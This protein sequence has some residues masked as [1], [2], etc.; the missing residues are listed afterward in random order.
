[1]KDPISHALEQRDIAMMKRYEEARQIVKD[2]AEVISM[3]SLEDIVKKY[4]HTNPGEV[5]NS[6]DVFRMFKDYPVDTWT[7]NN[8][9]RI[10]LAM[11]YMFTQE[12]FKVEEQ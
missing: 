4:I 2:D 5:P 10:G 7:D 11:A 12:Q 6:Q 3:A 1:M 8:R 9:H